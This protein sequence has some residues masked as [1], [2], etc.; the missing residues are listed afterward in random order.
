MTRN[1]YD[2]RGPQDLYFPVTAP[3]LKLAAVDR[4]TGRR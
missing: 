4:S 2:P 3:Y 1:Y